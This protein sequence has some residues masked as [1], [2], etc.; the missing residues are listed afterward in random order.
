MRKNIKETLIDII[1]TILDAHEVALKHAKSGEIDM[2]MSVFTECQEAMVK[3]GE[4]IEENEGENHKT[5]EFLQSYCDELYE[6]SLVIAENGE[7]N[8]NKLF[9][10]IALKLKDVLYSIKNDIKVRQEVVFM[11]YKASMWDALESVWKAADEDP[12][13]DAYVIPIPYYDRKSDHSFGEMHYEGEMFPDYVPIT[14]YNAYNLEARH[15]DAIYIHNPYDE[16]N[17]V[18]SV[19]P[20]FYAKEL[21]NYTDC[22]CYIPYFVV[23]SG[24]VAH[25]CTTAGC[26][27][28][29]KVF[30]QSEAVRDRY[31]DVFT[32]TYGNSFGDVKGKFVASGSPKFDA[33][34]NSKKEN[35]I[36]PEEWQKIIDNKKVILYNTSVGTILRGDKAYLEKLRDVL[37]YFKTQKDVVLWWR[38]HPLSATTYNSMRTT[39]LNEYITLIDEYK[40]AGYGIYDDTP[41]LQRAIICSD[42][43]YGDW[44]SLIALYQLTGKPVLFQ[45]IGAKTTDDFLDLTFEAMYDDGEYL[46]F[47]PVYFNALL[48][49]KK[50]TEE[51]TLVGFFPGEEAFA[52]RLF[53]DIAMHNNKLYFAPYSARK[54]AVYDLETGEFSN[55]D[56][57]KKYTEWENSVFSSV[58]VDDN[59]IYFIP[60]TYKAF[61]VYNAETNITQY[62]SGWEDSIKKSKYYDSL[63]A[64]GYFRKYEIVE[65]KLYFPCICTNIIVELDL[66]SQNIELIQ[67]G[68][69]N[70][71]FQGICK[72][73]GK[74][75]IIP[76]MGDKLC[77]LDLASGDIEPIEIPGARVNEI[78]APFVDVCVVDKKIILFP[79]TAENILTF[80]TTT[81][82]FEVVKE[83]GAP[84]PKNFFIGHY[85]KM[86]KSGDLF[87]A[88]D[89]QNNAVN[90]YT[91][92][93]ENK[94]TYSLK[95]Y[96]PLKEK[97]AKE[98]AQVIENVDITRGTTDFYIVREAVVTLVDLVDYYSN[99]Y[100]DVKYN[101]GIEQRAIV[102]KN[103]L[104]NPDGTA[105]DYIHKYVKRVLKDK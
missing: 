74:L 61:L 9:K 24:V 86:K 69:F 39:L 12:D 67:F 65:R 49:M 53:S 59:L 68:D 104:S 18:T 95:N 57:D 38:P 30:L 78:N 75:W 22:L 13:C 85:A 102:Q 36:I 32:R 81:K 43:Y 77:C 70:I 83:C 92:E 23:P 10:R 55:I 8:F 2:V 20:R 73:D 15:P 82:E 50:S 58:L 6:V 62:I 44:S 79:Y 45:S 90:T 5:I 14:H 80:D 64:Y 48:K 28:A 42:A 27:Y 76:D 31:E 101:V 91:S 88:V 54:I 105:G 40:T 41:D 33:V 60:R 4:V 25:H 29:D 26:C 11:P 21:K 84:V 100:D 87:Y 51:V 94:T 19:D 16:Y 46:W 63:F 71:R 93:F 66:D 103:M 89:L 98:K 99:H 96:S 34:A 47:T 35:F 97:I 3:I 56:F 37:S 1:P 52:Q 72:M 7:P 17:F